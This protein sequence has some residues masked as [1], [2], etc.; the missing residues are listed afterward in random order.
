MH[1]EIMAGPFAALAP[2]TLLAAIKSLQATITNCWPRLST[3]AYQSELIK[4]LVVCFLTIQ[5]DQDKLDGTQFSAI[6]AELTKT[7]A[8]LSAVT[9]TGGGE[10]EGK[11]DSSLQDKIAPLIAKEPVLQKL[12]EC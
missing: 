8:M 11:G 6:E 4:A 3:P 1:S 9:K 12:F 5:D 10:W 2:L 7:V